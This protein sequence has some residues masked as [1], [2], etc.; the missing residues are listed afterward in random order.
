MMKKAEILLDLLKLITISIFLFIIYLRFSPRISK[1]LFENAT[2]IQGLLYELLLIINIIMLSYILYIYI[3]KQKQRNELLADITSWIKKSYEKFLDYLFLLPYMDPIVTYL[4]YTLIKTP[5]RVLAFLYFGS[6]IAFLLILCLDVFYYSMFHLSYKFIY[7]LLIP[8]IVKGIL[9]L[10]LYA[11]RYISA[12]ITSSI[13]I[14]KYDRALNGEPLLLEDYELSENNTYYRSVEE[15][16]IIRDIIIENYEALLLIE[17]SLDSYYFKVFIR[18]IYVI[19]WSFI[20]YYYP[21][22]IIIY[23]FT[24]IHQFI[25]LYPQVLFMITIA[26]LYYWLHKLK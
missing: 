20:V 18:V 4:T 25:V 8:L 17:E 26:L 16:L 13:V 12:K 6:R 1:Y 14:S 5:R 15:A 22:P 19:L 21:L 24:I 3:G 7:I 11:N 9:E 2:I 23:T 10:C